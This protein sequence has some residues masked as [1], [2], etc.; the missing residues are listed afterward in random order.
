MR[1]TRARDLLAAGAVALAITFLLIRLLYDD[2]PTLPTLAG[3]SLA[4]LAMVEAVLGGVLYSWIQNRAGR[5]MVPPLLAAYA[6][7]LAKA[8]SLLGAIMGGCWLAVL[9]YVLPRRGDFPAAADDTVTA[10][11]GLFCA[12]I[13]IGAALWLEYSCR[14]PED[15]D[16]PP[17]DEQRR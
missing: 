11:V 5:P 10:T 7:M 12:A 15:E 9:G 2:M 8:S 16:Q 4:L 17:R 3:S 6:V 13:L 14:T 1:F